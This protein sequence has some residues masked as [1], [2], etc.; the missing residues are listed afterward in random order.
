MS[1][2]IEAEGLGSR[3]HAHPEAHMRC[4]AALEVVCSFVAA[5]AAVA[6]ATGVAACGSGR[7]GGTQG[8]DGGDAPLGHVDAPRSIDAP[9]PPTIDARVPPTI[10]ASIDASVCQGANVGVRTA[11]PFGAPTVSTSGLLVRVMNNCPFPVWI[12]GA[13][14]SGGNVLQP[15]EVKLGTGAEQDYDAHASFSSAR[16]TAFKDGPGQ[17]EIQ[18]VEMNFGGGQ[19]GYNIS[20]VDYLGVPAEVD[21][22]C[23]KT[24]CYAPMAGL[25]DGCPANLR[26]PDRCRSPGGWCLGHAGDAYCKA[27]DQSA[28]Q[29]LQVPRCQTELSTWLAGG[30]SQN[31]IGTTP[32]VYGCRD[33]W[34]SSPYCCSIVN[35]GM[36]GAADPFDV[37]AFYQATPY[38]TYARWVHE[39]CP[40]I[41]AFP[42][43]D[44]GEQGGYHQCA[45]SEVRITWCPGG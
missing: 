35:R 1:R 20:Y 4:R 29:A 42:Y 8:D 24:A 32:S 7:F 12:H 41:Y 21:A 22:A 33:F 19:L 25:L 16:V 30:G 14:N 44:A 38:N 28:V 37:C 27:L 2:A 5:V 17:N 31:N 6:I 9:K 45:A 18:F 43:D 34:A 13:G 10:D 11:P 3:E 15:D 26:E 23:G 39:R 40:A 36:V